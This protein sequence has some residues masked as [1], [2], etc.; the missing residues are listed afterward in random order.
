[1]KNE[2]KCNACGNVIDVQE[3]L[4]SE[5]LA[6]L[7]SEN[8]ERLKKIQAISDEKEAKLKA[9]ESKL[10]EDEQQ[11][12]ARI[13][14]EMKKRED[15]IRSRIEE[16]K[17]EE[18][19]ALQEALKEK[20][21][22]LSEFHQM[23]IRLEELEEEKKNALSDT[24]R[25]LKLAIAAKEREL[26]EENESALEMVQKQHEL[27]LNAQKK[28]TEEM[29]K[30]QQQGS[31]Q[32]Q[33]E[34]LEELIEK[35]LIQEFRLDEV[36]AIAK[37]VHGADVVHKIKTTSGKEIG[38][39]L[40][41]SKNAANWSNRWIPKLKEDLR[42]QGANIGVLV[43]EVF[44]SGVE[45]LTQIEGIWVCS[46]SEFK[47]L[48]HVLR[49][50]L[51]RMDQIEQVQ[52]NMEDKKERLYSYITSENFKQGIEQIIGSF[53]QMKVELD[54]EKLAMTKLWSQREARLS[55][56]LLGTSNLF[57][58]ISGIGGEDIQDIELL[59]LNHEG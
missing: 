24:E 3:A 19:E 27:A 15:S 51:R 45:R 20:S 47:G 54:K 57:G 22:S 8:D 1:M 33:G 17:K 37:G 7:K 6:Q 49:D 28:L 50:T 40:Y 11:Y 46:Y 59:D 43:T 36:E 39:V 42:N 56:V 4:S 23:K 10:L 2:I 30:K 13:N 48:C 9:R 38:A 31:M 14:E 26:R 53:S 44:P 16:N 35:F 25:R 21:R 52:F 18:F 5:L 32:L 12:Q 58:S 29:L 34:V 55:Q 41:E